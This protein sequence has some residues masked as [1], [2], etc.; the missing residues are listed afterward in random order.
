MAGFAIPHEKIC[1]VLGID[2]KT[3]YKHL[4]TELQ[5]GSAKVEAQLVGNLLKIASG[6]D[7][8]A[9]KAIQFALNCRFGWSAYAP[10]PVQEVL[11]KKAQ[12]EMDA[13]TAHE[14]D[15]DWSRLVN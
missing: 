15:P 5:T 4:G 3:L 6:A 7:G 2:L 9:L 13:F 10:K 8:A 12:A 1:L 11:G 14:E